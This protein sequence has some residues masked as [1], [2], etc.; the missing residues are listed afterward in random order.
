MTASP[1]PRTRSVPG[2]TL[3]VEGEPNLLLQG[4]TIAVT[5]AR[6]G[7]DVVALLEQR[8]ARVLHAPAVRILP[9]E[10]DTPLRVATVDC[11]EQPFDIVVATTGVG[12]GTWLEAAD[13][14]GLG[15]PLRNAL[16]AAQVYARGPKA[17]GA[18]H[19]SGLTDATFPPC[20][21]TWDLLERLLARDLSGARIVVQLHGADL[22]DFTR[23][24]RTAGAEVLEVPVYRTAP[25]EDDT[26]LGRLVEQVLVRDVQ[27]VTFTSA[28]A[29]T[30]LLDAATRLSSLDA[31]L[32]AFGEVLPAC[33]GDV[34]AAPLERLSVATVRPEQ[35][36]IGA[37][38]HALTSA[39]DRKAVRVRAAGHDLV[40][41]GDGA[42]V[43]EVFKPLPP[44]PMSVLRSLARQPGRVVPRAEL[45]RGLPGDGDE[46][47]AE[48]A[49]S[50][51]RTGLGDSR[52]VA[53]VVKRGYRLACDLVRPEE[54]APEPATEVSDA[55]LLRSVGGTPGIREA[56]ERLY[57]RLLDDPQLAHF[58]VGVDMPRLKRHQVLLMSQMLGG[59]AQYSGRDL[60][61]AHVGLA[62]TA[63]EYECMVTHLVAVLREL[64]APEATITCV[65]DALDGVAHHVVTADSPTRDFPARDFPEPA[66]SQGR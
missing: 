53:N 29:V 18:V 12:F 30:N 1:V 15:E 66:C 25:P 22:D 47:A 16:A 28:A 35:A 37:L 51:L 23:T 57:A 10:D 2:S 54:D 56:V 60:A 8:G 43:D 61:E 34:A 46:H 62:V 40:I 27:A 6:R 3:T 5:A 58:F 14:W 4:W 21:S 19:S 64:A 45:Q 42:V 63:S 26:V 7:A 39:L 41:R 32:D 44:A 13:G 11:L 52:C 20:E 38:V 9:L 17:S 33:V 50:R 24:L 36:R 59:P 49:I 65:R 31:L 48:M 55:P